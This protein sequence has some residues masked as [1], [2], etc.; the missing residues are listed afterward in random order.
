MSAVEL[1]GD[2]GELRRVS[3][4]RLHLPS[5]EQHVLLLQRGWQRERPDGGVYTRGGRRVWWTWAEGGATA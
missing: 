2:P 4:H 5:L 1:S 3:T